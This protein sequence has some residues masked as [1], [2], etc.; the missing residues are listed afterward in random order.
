MQDP[1]TPAINWQQVRELAQDIDPD[2]YDEAV[3]NF[4]DELHSASPD[5]ILLQQA[6]TLLLQDEIDLPPS[7]RDSGIEPDELLIELFITAGADLNT[8]NPYGETPLGLAARYGYDELATYLLNAGADKKATNAQGRIPA[9]LA[10]T[11]ALIELLM[12]D[13]QRGLDELLRAPSEPTLPDYL[14]DGDKEAPDSL[15]AE[16]ERLHTTNSEDDDDSRFTPRH[17][18]GLGE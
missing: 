5:Y 12:P 6:A 1:H 14:I 16:L 11:P 17:D 2:D 8:R 10:S 4:L 18:C 13:E 7:L 3:I 15:A 9:D